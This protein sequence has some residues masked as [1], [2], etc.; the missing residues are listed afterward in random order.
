[1]RP[2]PFLVLALPAAL[3][4][5]ACGGKV[6]DS[7]EAESLIKNASRGLVTSAT[8]PADVD[9]EEGKTFTCTATLKKG[10]KRKVTVKMG[11][12]QNDRVQLSLVSAK[13]A[14]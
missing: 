8:C 11:A 10:G 14:K 7:G 13:P 12:V 5:A 6:I 4:F 1:V 9:V 2:R 3:L